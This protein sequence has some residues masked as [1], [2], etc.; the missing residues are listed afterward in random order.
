M[1]RSVVAIAGVLILAGLLYLFYGGSAAPA[2]QPPLL[3]LNTGNF[4]QLRNEFNRAHGAVRVMALLS[5][6]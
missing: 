5:P 2:G 3:A 1:K 6:T 4:D